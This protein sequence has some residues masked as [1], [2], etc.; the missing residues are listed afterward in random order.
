MTA[1]TER[2][3]HGPWNPGI[4]SQLPAAF[5]PLATIFRAEN[6]VTSVEEAHERS[7]FTG[8]DPEDHVAFRPERLAVHELLIR[9]I[10]RR[11]GARR[12]GT[13][14]I[15]GSISARSPRR[16][17]PGTST[18]HMAEIVRAYHELRRARGRA[19]SSASWPRASFA[20]P[21]RAEARPAEAA[22]LGAASGATGRERPRGRD[23]KHRGQRERR[24]LARMAAKAEPRA[25]TRSQ[26]SSIAPCSGSPS[27][28]RRPARPAARRPGAAD[29]ARPPD[30]VCNE[31]GSEMI[32]RMIEPHLRRAAA[33]RGLPAAAARRPGRW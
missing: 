18:P 7:A 6:V 14:T 32:G 25:T 1:A 20:P 13:T 2:T 15:S 30:L 4:R 29:R 33:R 31:H 17:S 21:D 27:A 22:L 16:S 23:R 19:R 26:A 3:E 5:L 28:I 24:I 12:P 9:V 10:G 11:L 8:L